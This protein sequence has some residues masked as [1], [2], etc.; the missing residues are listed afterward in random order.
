MPL[1]LR[2]CSHQQVLSGGTLTPHLLTQPPPDPPQG[3]DT[4]D[5]VFR[6]I[7]PSRREA[8]SQW[9]AS[10][11]TQP[12]S[13]GPEGRSSLPGGQ[14]AE[15]HARQWATAAYTPCLA[16]PEAHPF[17]MG[18][19]P[20]PQQLGRGPH[21]QTP[22]LHKIPYLS[23][24]NAIHISVHD[25][26]IMHR[27]HLATMATL[28]TAFTAREGGRKRRSLSELNICKLFGNFSNQHICFVT[29]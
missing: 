1:P 8:R 6:E 5:P 15:F 14:G 3:K 16:Q 18:Q 23:F 27:K 24:L 19:Q 26:Y 20:L 7:C 25:V 2:G 13:A 4:L 21:N 22:Q 10:L 12:L 17:S 11:G 9:G 29:F 28:T